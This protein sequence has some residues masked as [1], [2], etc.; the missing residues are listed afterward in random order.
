MSGPHRM[1]NS[2]EEPAVEKLKSQDVSVGKTGCGDWWTA[3][4][5]S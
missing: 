4:P 1:N 2:R 3:Q 5:V